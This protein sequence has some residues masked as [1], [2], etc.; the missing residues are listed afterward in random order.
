LEYAWKGEFEM[1]VPDIQGLYSI[2][3]TMLDPKKAQL[4]VERAGKAQ[5]ADQ[6]ELSSQSQTIHKLAAERTDS[7]SRAAQV[8]ELKA[9]HERGELKAD[10]QA[11]AEAMVASG[12][13]DDLIGA[14]Q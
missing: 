8:A 14:K 10:T 9:L 11:T 5:Q 13:F 2:A 3:R 7:R 12:L 1:K 6:V 4:A